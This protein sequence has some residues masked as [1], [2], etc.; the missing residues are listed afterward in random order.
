MA[1]VGIIAE[2]NPLHTGHCFLLNAARRL[3]TVTAVLSGNFVQRGDTAIAEKRV[4]AR[5]ALLCG[6]DIVLEMPVCYSMSSAQSFALH[7]VSALKAAGCDTVMFGSEC[8]DINML[9]AA[10]DILSSDVYKENLKKHLK[11]GMTFAAARERAADIGRGLLSGANNNL[12]IE[13]IA[14]AR[15]INADMKF[16]TV[17]RL[18]AAHDAETAENGYAAASLLREKMRVLRFLFRLCYKRAYGGI[19]KRAL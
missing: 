15:A 9:M 8:G 14:A 7:G 12:A 16:L 19:C 2:F 18:G 3:G 10:A 17:R 11:T 13:Y 1:R 6:A 4:R 5:A